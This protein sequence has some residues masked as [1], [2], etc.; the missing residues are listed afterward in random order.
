MRASLRLGP[1]EVQVWCANLDACSTNL[2]TLTGYLSNEE[3]ERASLFKVPLARD[4][5]LAGRATLREILGSYL[6]Q[7]PSSFFIETAPQGKPRLSGRFNALDVRFS[8]SRSYGLALFAFSLNREVGVD[9][10]KIRP[11]FVREGI[12]ELYFSAREQQDLENT[13]SEFRMEAFFRCWTRKEA[14]IKARGE[15]LNIPLDSFSVSLKPDEPA[16]LSSQDSERW[17]LYSI[18]TPPGFAGAL[19]AKAPQCEVIYQEW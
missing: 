11:E 18:D 12:A 1:N 3:L 17:K 13:P 2:A 16:L 7:P 9:I 6:E 19:V 14:Y 10:E 5:F 15:G 8:L 4:R